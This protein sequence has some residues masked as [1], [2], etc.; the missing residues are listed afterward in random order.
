MKYTIKGTNI[1]ERAE[2]NGEYLLISQGKN[3]NFCLNETG[4][5]IYVALKDFSSSEEIAKHMKKLYPKA[6][7]KDIEKDVYDILKMFEVYELIDLED[8]L[9][10]IDGI[11]C[12]FNG[13][14]FYKEVNKFIIE[15][16][17]QSGGIRQCSTHGKEEYYAPVQM[18]A[19]V[20]QQQEFQIFVQNGSEIIGFVSLTGQPLGFSKT[21]L[22]KDIL[23]SH[24]LSHDQIVDCIDKIVS[25]VKNY[26]IT[27]AKIGKIRITFN[28]SS[29]NTALIDLLKE[30]G[31]VLSAT[32]KDETIAGDLYLY[33]YILK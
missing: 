7:I 5:E 9:S 1:I 19:R 2:G 17:S 26:F 11:K 15:E 13:D 10:V 33:D 3:F 27:K 32:L 20:V 29:L 16:L 8:S 22:I 4:H 31:F 21:L 23:F 28:S 18:R 6:D 25:K 30:F 12:S 24:N 14:L